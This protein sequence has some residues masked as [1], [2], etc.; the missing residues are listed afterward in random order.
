[1]DTTYR[2]P[3]PTEMMRKKRPY[4]FSDSTV[5]NE[6]ELS[7][8]EFSHFLETL[9][10]RNQHKDFED[11]ARKLCERE[12][13]PNLRPQT[14]PEGGGDGKI[15][16]DTYPVSTEVSD[17]WYFGDANSG[18]ENWGF[19]FSAKK[20]WSEKVRS[21]TT[22]MIETGRT[23]DRV[24]FATSRPA[25][26][27]DRLRIEQELKN[28]HGVPVTILDREWIIEKTIGNGHEDL[29]YE[30][31]KAGRHDP[32]RLQL[33]PN[34]IR[35][36][37]ELD[38][39]ENS[40]ANNGTTKRDLNKAI[41]R[42]FDAACLS[43]ELEVHRHLTEGRFHR[44]IRLAE[45]NGR[46]AHVLRARYEHAWTIFWWFSD[47]GSIAE[48]Y[49]T[50]EG[51][52][53]DSD[54][55]EDASR[56][57]NL[58]Q[59]LVG[60]SDQ[61]WET[62][63]ELKIKERG[64]R[65]QAHLAKISQNATLP[66]NALYGSALLELHKLATA[67]PNATQDELDGVWIA[68]AEIVAKASGMG[69]FPATM[70]DGV[71][72]EISPFISDSSAFDKLLE[73]LAEFM[74]ERQR[75]G[76]AGEI[77]LNRGRQKVESNDAID[78]I[79]WLGK[80]SHYFM[81]EEYRE[82]QFETLLMLSSA[83]RAAGLLW[84]ARAT[85]L[86]AL[87]QIKALSANAGEQRPELIPNVLL[88]IHINLELGR[89]PDFLFGV[90]WLRSLQDGLTL[91]EQAENH[92]AEKFQEQDRLLACLLA[93]S[94]QA[95][96]VVLE[97]LPDVLEKLGLQFSRLILLYRLGYVDLLLQEGSLPNETA[98]QEIPG[99]ADLLASQPAASSLAKHPLSFG[100]SPQEITTKV[101]GVDVRATAQNEQGV[102]ILEAQMAAMEAFSATAIRCGTMPIASHLE[103]TIDPCTS[104][105]KP[106]IEFE[107]ESMLVKTLW[108][109]DFLIEDIGRS[110]DASNFLV[111]F[112]INAFSATTTLA[113][114]YDSFLEMLENEL[115]LE[116]AIPLANA[117]HSNHRI[118]GKH[119]LSLHDLDFLVERSYVESDPP[120]EPNKSA[121]P[122]EDV[123]DGEQTDAPQ[124]TR[125][126]SF[127]V[128]SVVNTHLWDQA[129][130][131]GIA[132]LYSD[133][134]TPPII[135]FGFTDSE[136]GKAIFRA[137]RQE[138]GERDEADSIRL[139]LLTG[140]DKNEPLAYRAHITRS[141]TTI[142]TDDINDGKMFWQLS[143][144][145]TMY[146]TSKAHFD[147]FIERYEKLGCYFIAPVEM[148]AAGETVVHSDVALLKREIHIKEAW[149]VGPDDDAMMGLL[150]DDE[151]AIPEGISDP[152]C[153]EVK[154]L[155]RR[156][157]GNA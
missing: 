64:E 62:A 16:S 21:D 67:G 152:P 135:G 154:S 46:E 11:F 20:K 14:G 115:V 49:E 7:R 106:E 133:G 118:F 127:G 77:F 48:E 23:Y 103:L 1:M 18:T 19:A 146:P 124:S 113:G 137:W 139:S 126:D 12:I 50:I 66:N 120:A 128:H 68:L 144:M 75:D 155:R 111:N 150:E 40:L 99:M 39:L 89:I 157:K 69:E 119:I 42:A 28:K 2:F 72:E 54:L 131:M 88:Y 116:R 6:Y 70:L 32:S 101:L 125:H 76:K 55:S 87:V 38:A 105:K 59:V 142:E 30:V 86:A 35:R 143:R 29:A 47:V 94:P 129:Q 57:C 56:V 117:A 78:A 90:L 134:P 149:T 13:C 45:K 140:I 156:L 44:A 36:Q 24:I 22:G 84:A 138:F 151:I 136:A 51:L 73:G 110:G 53:F 108:P 102:L 60:R 145:Q 9:T 26:S 91:S 15:D 4:L 34:D 41:T 37:R 74:G 85:C 17:T 121:L 10:D 95:V 100:K 93:A 3:T 63:T 147:G 123:D 153:D 31:L 107:A 61:G 130:W 65:L 33:G 27:Q 132:Y 104:L 80:A 81:K 98:V 8:S 58:F 96:M 148:T 83:Y 43:R 109:S 5:T 112:C 79:A 82:E 141:R 71:V 25:R 114:K 122:K 97:R 52:A 92:L